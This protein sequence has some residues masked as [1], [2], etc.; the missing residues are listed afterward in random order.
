MRIELVTR[1]AKHD[2]DELNELLDQYKKL[3]K[4]KAELDEQ[5]KQLKA[6]A[7]EYAREQKT[8]AGEQAE[9][10]KME[11]ESGKLIE[12]IKNDKSDLEDKSQQVDNKYAEVSSKANTTTTTTTTK[13]KTTTTKR[14]ATAVKRPLPRRSRL[15]RK[16]LTKLRFRP[17]QLRRKQ[18]SQS[19]KQAKR[20]LPQQQQRL[21]LSLIIQAVLK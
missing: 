4:T 1:V 13:K 10:L 12:Q 11:Q 18:L 5:I 3:E 17:P 16:S 6:K 14:V 7:E 2:N 8:L 9:L 19:L 15:R 21:R 20:P